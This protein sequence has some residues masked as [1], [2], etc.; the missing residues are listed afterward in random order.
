[1]WKLYRTVV[2]DKRAEAFVDKESLSASRFD[3]H[4]RGVEWLLARKPQSG[5]PRKASDPKK[6]LVYVFPDNNLAGTK[7]LWVL[8]SYNEDQVVIHAVDFG[9]ED[10]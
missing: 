5:I 9:I 8:Y 2:L 10:D 7:D 3:D 1:M 6:Y 4:W